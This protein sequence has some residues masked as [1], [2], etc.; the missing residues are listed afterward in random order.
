MLAGAL[1]T[2]SL[3]GATKTGSNGL[4]PGTRL[5]LESF[6]CQVKSAAGVTRVFVVPLKL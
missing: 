6:S 4:T 2:T 1:Q 5:L 3:F